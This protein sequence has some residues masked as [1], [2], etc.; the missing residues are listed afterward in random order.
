MATWEFW[1]N[2]S[3]RPKLSYQGILVFSD[4]LF[5]GAGPAAFPPYL[6]KSFGRPGYSS[7][8]TVKAEYQL[9]NGDY[10]QVFYPT[11]GFET[12]PVNI[13][14]V[15]ANL[16]SNSTPDTAAHIFNALTVMGKT[17]RYESDA[18]I[19]AEGAFK[20]N[21][22]DSLLAYIKGH[23][24]MISMLELDT[25]GN[26]TGTWTL[27]KPLLT[28][29]DFSTISYDSND[30]STIS[31]S[32]NYKNFDFDTGVNGW[33]NEDLL[34]K[35]RTGVAAPAPVFSSCEGFPEDN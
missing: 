24:Q 30:I 4:L 7:L 13:T 20:R 27:H 26:I 11:Q 5:G 9:P 32:F 8:E 29:V 35:I 1:S 19:S 34:Q 15:D 18:S 3:L 23:P 16:D 2:K 12:K 10:S 22:A 6:I 14:L 21:I 33:G 25:G 17:W 31:L 28:S